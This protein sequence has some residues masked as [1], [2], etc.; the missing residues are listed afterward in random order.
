MGHC[1]ALAQTALA[2]TPNAIQTTKVNFFRYS[3][4]ACVPRRGRSTPQLEQVHEIAKPLEGEMA[5][6]KL[7]CCFC[8]S[9]KGTIQL[10]LIKPL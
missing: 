1:H 3:K 2:V 8:L 5:S 4:H 10:S 9:R 6:E 7:D